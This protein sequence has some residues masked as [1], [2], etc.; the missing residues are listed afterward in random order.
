MGGFRGPQVARGPFGQGGG[1]LEGEPPPGTP[2]NSTGPFRKTT[3]GGETGAHITADVT[4]GGTG[5]P[6]PEAGDLCRAR[7]TGRTL[8]RA[9]CIGQLKGKKTI[10][11]IGDQASRGGSAV[12]GSSPFVARERWGTEGQG[13]VRVGD[14]G[15]GVGWGVVGP[16]TLGKT[17]TRGT[18]Q[19]HGSKKLGRGQGSANI[20]VA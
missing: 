4:G 20:A 8:G 16:A 9:R 2:V 5:G 1:T 19:S 14:R 15:P 11:T 7:I 3:T 13:L 18:R 6:S 12:S 17:L 10:T